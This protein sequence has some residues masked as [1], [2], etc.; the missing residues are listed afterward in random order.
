MTLAFFAIGTPAILLLLLAVV[1]SLRNAFPLPSLSGLCVGAGL[2]T[3]VVLAR[4]ASRCV[5][6]NQGQPGLTSSCTAPDSASLVVLAAGS[7]VIG[8]V[9]GL[10]AIGRVRFSS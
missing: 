3:Y 5:T 7:V 4:A 9:F 8:I 6:E 10:V 1:G 2:A